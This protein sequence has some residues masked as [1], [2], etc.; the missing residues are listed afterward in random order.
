MLCPSLASVEDHVGW[1]RAAG[2][3]HIQA[4]DITPRVARTWDLCAAILDSP[5]VKPLL[6][7]VDEQTRD[8]LNAFD[9]MRQGYAKGALGYGMF[10]ASKPGV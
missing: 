4:E 1:L 7:A 2:F 3:E 8:F 6:P 10:T 5:E 9:L